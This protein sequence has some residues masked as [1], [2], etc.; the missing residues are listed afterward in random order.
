MVDR[1][2]HWDEMTDKAHAQLAK[3]GLDS[4]VEIARLVAEVRG[5][6]GGP[7]QEARA[8]LDLVIT[9][10]IND[11]VVRLADATMALV[12]SSDDNTKTMSALGRTLNGL[13]FG[14]LVFAGAQVWLAFRN[15]PQPIHVNVPAPVVQVVPAT[16]A[17]QQSPVT[18]ALK[19]RSPGA[20][21]PPPSTVQSKRR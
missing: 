21:S 1:T 10:G 12:K 20:P 19:P 18:P 8:K 5:L 4:S 15:P 11:G 9:K 17:P 7:Q 6:A 16:P 13:T 3:L 2:G 14:L